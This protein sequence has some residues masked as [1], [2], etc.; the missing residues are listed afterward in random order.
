MNDLRY[1]LRLFRKQPGFT[2]VAVLSIALG[3]GA[4]TLMFSVVHSVLIRSL[5]FRDPGRLVCR[6][7]LR[8]KSQLDLPADNGHD[9]AD[10]FG[11]LHLG[12]RFFCSGD[13]EL[14]QR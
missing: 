8:A 6:G 12:G 4:N 10:L 7:H 9:G 13:T 14:R 1:A 11:I 2:A 5:P 3:I